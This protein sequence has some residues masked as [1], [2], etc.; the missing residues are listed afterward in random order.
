VSP[1]T[2]SK[3]LPLHWYHPECAWPLVIPAENLCRQKSEAMTHVG[4]TETT[5]GLIQLGGLSLK[6]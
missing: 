5:R 6:C 2:F 1:A 4:G 3:K